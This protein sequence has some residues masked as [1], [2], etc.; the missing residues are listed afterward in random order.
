MSNMDEYFNEM[1]KYLE[2]SNENTDKKEMNNLNRDELYE[3]FMMFQNYLQQQNNTTNISSTPVPPQNNITLSTSNNSEGSK[4]RDEKEPEQGGPIPSQDKPK[5]F[6]DIPIQPK[7]KNFYELLESNLASANEDV[8]QSS[9][10][11]IIKY[12]PRK[13]RTDVLNISAPTDQKKYK[14]YSQNF[15]KDFGTEEQIQEVVEKKPEK[16]KE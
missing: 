16:H 11:K 4:N 14:Y 1:T 8:P 6:D 10:K 7:A 15:N 9:N 5:S 12:E 13:K 3:K 2:G